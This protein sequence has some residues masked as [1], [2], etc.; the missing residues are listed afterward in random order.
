MKLYESNVEVVNMSNIPVIYQLCRMA[1]IM[2]TVNRTVTWRSDNSSVSPGFLI[3]SL[4]ISTLSN[5]K[6]LWK[7]HE[8]WTQSDLDF[9]YPD[10]ELRTEWL[11]DDAYA[12]ALD[13]LG[14]VNMMALVSKICLEM[15]KM[16]G[17][18]MKSIHLDTTSKSVQGRYEEMA[19]GNFDITYGYSKDKRPDLLQ[20]KMGAAVQQDS[21][22]VMGEMLAGNHTDNAWNP[23]AIK[24]MRALF[25]SYGY[26]GITFV[27]DAATV[28]SFDNLT[29]L[30]G[31][32]FISRL[33]E[34]FG[35]AH[36]LKAR[37]M[38]ED[39]FEDIGILSSKATSASYKLKSYT[40]EL[41]GTAYRFLIV[42]STALE[43]IKKNTLS[44]NTD[45]SIAA[46]SKKA[47]RLKK[48]SFACQADAQTALDAF[49]KTVVHEK[50]LYQADVQAVTKVNFGKRGRPKSDVSGE[51]TTTFHA[52]CELLGPDQEILAKKLQSESMFVLISSIIDSRTTD[53]ELLTE[54]K[55]QNS[56]EEAFRFLKSP[57]YLGQVLLNKKERVEAMGYVFIL[58]LMLA[59]YLQY[60]VRKSLNDNNEYVLDP[61][62]KKNMRPSVKRIFEILEDVLVIS[63]HQGRFFPSNLNPRIMDMIRWAGFDPDIYLKN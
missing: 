34:T 44:R 15:L 36:T 3:E 61:G 40:E 31:I 16:H 20:F 24:G 63:T 51:L 49:V 2:E 33:P 54:Y 32:R 28:A 23:E 42:H 7:M 58:V 1:R 53:R 10:L 52:C 60:R 12:R 22:V 19:T 5:R 56:I 14:E 18:E 46:L 30:K 43:A 4:V 47:E 55:H 27:G 57:V 35:I 21:L 39:D 38:E 48:Q 13:K 11:N 17:L 26:T 41:N 6:P 59:S 45:K 37:A 50:I 8:F 25:E 29:E 62:N 9:F